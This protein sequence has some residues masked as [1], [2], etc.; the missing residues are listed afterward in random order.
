MTQIAADPKLFSLSTAVPSPLSLFRRKASSSSPSLS[1][2]KVEEGT[3]KSAPS[4]RASFFGDPSVKGRDLR[5]LALVCLATGGGVAQ[6]L[7]EGRTGIGLR[8]TMMVA[9]GFKGFLA[10]LW[11]T[12]K[13]KKK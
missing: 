2:G 11:L 13:G 4:R 3:D 6:S 7:L 12:P 9:A 8:G 1:H 5:I 10:L